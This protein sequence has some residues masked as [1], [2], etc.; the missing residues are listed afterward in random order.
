M[1]PHGSFLKR[2]WLLPIL[3]VAAHVVVLYRVFSRMAWTVA[4][5]LLVLLALKH[6]GAIGSI[7]VMFRR[8]WRHRS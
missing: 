6:I 2:I 7:Y 1:Q 5:G 3:V 8:R 4:V